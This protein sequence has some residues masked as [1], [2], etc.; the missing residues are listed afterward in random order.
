MFIIRMHNSYTFAHGKNLNNYWL[1]PFF[2][3]HTYAPPCGIRG[4][5]V[6]SYNLSP[7]KLKHFP[8]LSTLYHSALSL[9]LSWALTMCWSTDLSGC[10]YGEMVVIRTNETDWILRSE[11]QEAREE[12]GHWWRGCI[13]WWWWW[14]IGGQGRF[15][16]LATRNL[17]KIW[18]LVTA[19]IRHYMEN[20]R[21]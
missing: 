18:L 5:L 4:I 15:Y 21:S 11:G 14:E 13:W 6:I 17:Q 8:S 12:D 7:P 16:P 2:S 20:F 3:Y 9:Y 10:E 1:T 19:K